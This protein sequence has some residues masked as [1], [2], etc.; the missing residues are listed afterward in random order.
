MYDIK[1]R[2]INHRSI[3]SHEK[4]FRTPK[5]GISPERGCNTTFDDVTHIQLEKNWTKNSR[6][7][8]RLRSYSREYVATRKTF[9]NISFM[10]SK[11]ILYFLLPARTNVSKWSKRKQRHFAW[12]KHDTYIISRKTN[13]GEQDNLEYR[14]L[15]FF[16]RWIK[17]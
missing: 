13:F 14:T 17:Y 5:K 2:Y 16:R 15:L 9:L 10:Q 3:S 7:K 8:L 12:N 6:I 11:E 4:R 1:P